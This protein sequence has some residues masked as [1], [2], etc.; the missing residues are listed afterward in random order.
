MSL[1]SK[2]RAFAKHIARGLT[3]TEAARAAGYAQENAESL[4]VT[5]SRLQRHPEIQ[6]AAHAER[7]RRLQGDLATLAISTLEGLLRSNET[8]AAARM[9][10]VKF[11]LE[12]AGHGLE[13]RRLALKVTDDSDKPTSQ[14]TAA[15]LE[16]LVLIAADRVRAERAAIIDAEIV[17]DHDQ[18]ATADEADEGY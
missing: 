4:H 9:Q 14:L 11:V 17:L 13:S 5:A 2:Q 7:E 1:T 15:D 12:G 10:A 18:T 6:M 16:R 8:P 3:A